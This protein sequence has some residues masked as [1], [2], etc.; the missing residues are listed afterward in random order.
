[1]RSIAWLLAF[2]LW[3]GT[4]VAAP[5]DETR[6]LE[7][8]RRLFPEAPAF[9]AVQAPT[10]SELVAWLE[11]RET[12][13]LASAHLLAAPDA[14]LALLLQPGRIASGPHGQWTAPMLTLAK[15]GQPA[16]PAI[17]DRVISILG[18]G[19]PSAVGAIYPLMKA[20]GS[21]GAA[22][23]PA[24]LQIAEA[25][26]DPQI[27]VSALNEIVGLEPRTRVFGQTLS[28]W[29]FWRPVDTR[30][31]DLRRE[32]VPQLP[33]VRKLLERTAAE[34][35]PESFVPHRPAAYLL[36]RWGEGNDRA[37][38]LQALEDLA[39][40]N[41]PYYYNLEAIRLLHAL[42]A[43]A[44]AR[45]IRG[46]PEKIPDSTDTKNL[47]VLSLAIALHQLGDHDYVPLLTAALRD[48]RAH[49]RMD[50]ARFVASSAEVSHGE[51]LLPL[52]NDQ[53]AWNGRTVA[54]VAIESLQRLTLERFGA[55]SKSWRA[56]FERNRETPRATL[57][58]GR[59]KTHL[60]GIEQMPI[61]DANRA[62]EEFDAAD[63][64]ALFPLIDRYLERRDLDARAVG[65]NAGFYSGGT[66]PVG[67]YGPRIV[68]LQ[69]DMAMR[70]VP[71][72]LQRLTAC[73]STA[74]PDV[75]M[76]G[77]L[78]LAAFDRPRA[79]E[80]LALDA[81]SG[82]AWQRRRASEFLLQ[83]GDSRGIPGLLDALASDQAAIRGFAC[84]DLRVY[85][86]RP[87]SCGASASAS[88]V[89]AWRAWWAQ[90][91]STFRVKSREAELDLQAFP[92]IAPVSV[93]GRPVQ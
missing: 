93:G 32:I 16:I 81:T 37:R 9:A 7:G 91:Q 57:V 11:N 34:W 55:D 45:L 48:P 17:R 50:V 77:A 88:E 29:I 56:W 13:W 38:G 10:P 74:D 31:D 69:L 43:P 27:T 24:L 54:E 36:A 78:A 15:L 26:K 70:Q 33:R 2:A 3:P 22:A 71:G 39:R 6:T 18:A 21:S 67:L 53:A 49:V 61:W 19:D 83:L 59:V 84:R 30:L 4:S 35:K 90:A 58:A 42:Q 41:E 8:A 63:G 87:L 72:A 60:A 80:R 86:Q 82:E 23:V 12:E 64:A 28:P 46:L 40:A 66:G 75:R 44:T 92:T 65:P 52:V 14:A 47:Y 5:Q 62:I 73:L 85:T 76:F 1:M 68:T 89:G 25:S 51:L 79:I 20:L